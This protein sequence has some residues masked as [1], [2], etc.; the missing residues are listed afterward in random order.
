ML[1]RTHKAVAILIAVALVCMTLAAPALAKN[2]I[3]QKD[4]SGEQMAIDLVIVRPLGLAATALGS[5][6][7]LA[8]LPFS[9]PGGNADKASEKLVAEPFKFT[10]ARKLGDF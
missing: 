6:V 7:F 10:F 2:P 1:T 5:V 3:E 8:S 9:I 4:V